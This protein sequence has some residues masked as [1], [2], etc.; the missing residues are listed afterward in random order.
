MPHFFPWIDIYMGCRPGTSWRGLWG[1]GGPPFK[2]PVEL[3]QKGHFLKE[4]INFFRLHATPPGAIS[5]SRFCDS[6]ILPLN[7]M[8]VVINSI[9]S[10]LEKVRRFLFALLSP[11]MKNA[12]RG[13]FAFALFAFLDWIIFTNKKCYVTIN[14]G[15]I[16]RQK[17]FFNF[18]HFKTNHFKTKFLPVLKINKNETPFFGIL[19]FLCASAK[20]SDFQTTTRNTSLPI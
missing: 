9:T 11:P 20:N 18:Y 12:G 8:T 5:I 15:R 2:P 4:M 16:S 17:A 7:R 10:S 14:S 3:P 6:V 19:N 13:A 1:G